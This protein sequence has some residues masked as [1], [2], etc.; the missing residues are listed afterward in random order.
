ML[1]VMP[2]LQMTDEQG[3]STK[4]LELLQQCSYHMEE[5]QTT[6]DISFYN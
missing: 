6:D 2:A 5:Q 3:K 1:H 4:T